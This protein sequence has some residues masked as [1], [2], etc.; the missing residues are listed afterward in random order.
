MD[1]GF[2]KNLIIKA[3]KDNGYEFFGDIPL[4]FSEHADV[5]SSVAFL[6]KKENPAELAKNI[7]K[8]IEDNGVFGKIQA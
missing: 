6:I 5:S 2:V 8:K 7:A 1:A 3:I 4:E